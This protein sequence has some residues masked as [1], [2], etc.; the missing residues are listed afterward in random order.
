M[1]GEGW[2][3]HVGETGLL[4]LRMCLG[5]NWGGTLQGQVR[6]ARVSFSRGAVLVLHPLG[7][8]SGIR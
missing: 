3:L 4:L 7:V 5:D 6:L 8:E 2:T 1:T